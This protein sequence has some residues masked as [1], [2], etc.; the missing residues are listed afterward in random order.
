MKFDVISNFIAAVWVG[1]LTFIFTPIYVRY[2][3]VEAYGLIGVLAALQASL[4]MLDLGFSQV[5]ARETARYVGGT[6]STQSIKNLIRSIET[7]AVA[8]AFVVALAIALPAD[9]IAKSWLKAGDFPADGIVASIRLMGVLVALRLLEGLF[10]G[11]VIGLHRQFGL[12]L[13]TVACT[14]ARAVGAL[15]IFVY[16]SATIEAFFIWQVIVSGINVALLL[17]LIYS[18]FSERNIKG[19]FSIKELRRVA[20]FAAGLTIGSVLGIVLSQTD[21][22]LLSKLLLLR[23]FGEYTLAATLAAGPHLFAAPITQAVQP[24]FARAVARSDIPALA[25]AF[26]GS[27]QLLSATVGAA[28]IVIIAFSGDVLVLWLQDAVLAARLA[29]LV[30]VLAIGSLLNGLMWLP[31]ALQLAHGW[32]GLT[33]RATFVALVVLVPLLLVIT[34]IYGA[35]GAATAWCLLNF[36]SFTITAHVMFRR[37]LPK[38]KRRWYLVDIAGPLLAA[39]AVV[40][41]VKL[42]APVDGS[43]WMRIVVVGAA[44]VGAASAAVL[45]A[46]MLRRELFATLVGVIKRVRV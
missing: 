44:S 14:T 11:A 22:L 40:L 38:E 15:G 43:I 18:S 39:A 36:G 2:L 19:V 27:S 12:N 34:P 9:W 29:P 33:V 10:R 23:E 26:H 16:I 6:V 37:I 32:A 46:P 28:A 41:F 7:I 13:I 4:G 1:V 42:I 35:M 20:R 21:K 31:Y 24:R 5:V 17:V 3:G 30:S 25:T 8:L 45:A